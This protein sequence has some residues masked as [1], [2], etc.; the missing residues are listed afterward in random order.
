MWHQVQR[1]HNT[2]PNMKKI[3]FFYYTYILLNML[4]IF[5]TQQFQRKNMW[6]DGYLIFPS[7]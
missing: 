5:L 4:S 1:I 6:C 3:E 7:T 2:M